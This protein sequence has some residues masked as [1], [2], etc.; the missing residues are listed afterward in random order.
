MSRRFLQHRE[1]L[2]S[3]ATDGAAGPSRRLADREAFE[4]RS[5]R[6]DAVGKDVLAFAILADL[7]RAPAMRAPD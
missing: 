4:R 3:V 1:A 7:H 2:R 5:F 6:E